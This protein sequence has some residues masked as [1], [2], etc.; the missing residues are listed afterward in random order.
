MFWQISCLEIRHYSSQ[1]G[2]ELSGF[3]SIRHC[4]HQSV[5]DV[6]AAK[7]NPQASYVGRLSGSGN[8]CLDICC[9]GLDR[10]VLCPGSWSCSNVKM[11]VSH[12]PDSQAW[13]TDALNVSGE[14]LVSRVPWP[15]SLR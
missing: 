2:S 7:M 14:G 4:C 8:R 3:Q 15:S 9:E 10:H 13:E 12:V 5:V 1:R 11:Y 6:F